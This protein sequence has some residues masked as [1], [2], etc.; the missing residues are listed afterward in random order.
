MIHAL[1]SEDKM[2]MHQVT[3]DKEHPSKVRIGKHYFYMDG[4]LKSNLDL[5]KKIIT[6]DWDMIFLVDGAEGSGK[7]VLT[8]QAA[9][10]CDP[11]LTLDRVTFTPNEFRKAI[12]KAEKYQA[13]VYDEAYSGLS[14]RA[15]MSLINRTL[16]KML[17][18][19]RQKNL[20]VFVVMPSFFDVDKYVALWRSRVLIHVYLGKTFQRGYFAFYNTD[21]KKDMYIKGKKFYGYVAV[22]NFRGRFT[23]YY[24]VDEEGYRAKKRKALVSHESEGDKEEF[25]RRMREELFERLFTLKDRVPY[26]V[27]AEILGIHEQT[28]YKWVKRARKMRESGE[29]DYP[30]TFS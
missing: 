30:P 2:V 19:I 26:K 3:V 14:S 5:V 9:Y 4:Y 6:K 17:A 15:A 11:T 16:I 27:K 28:Y 7:S 13:V 22:P 20:F 25:D 29:N 23:N 12:L 18:E 24:T 8:M 1:P 10:Y 21:R